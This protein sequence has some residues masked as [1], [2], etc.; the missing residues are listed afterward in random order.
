MRDEKGL[1]SEIS[2]WF[3]SCRS[4][5]E[6]TAFWSRLGAVRMLGFRMDIRRHPWV[7]LLRFHLP[8]GQKILG[9]LAWRGD[10]RPRPLVV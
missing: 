7:H 10:F 4:E 6:N 8:N 3:S 1:A 9:A 5:I 2:S